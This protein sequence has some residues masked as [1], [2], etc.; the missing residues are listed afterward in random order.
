MFDSLTSELGKHP[1]K[2]CS[3]R[4]IQL[5]VEHHQGVML[6]WRFSVSDFSRETRSV[7]GC[8]C[9]SDVFRRPRLPGQWAI[10]KG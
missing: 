2:L 4:R 3:R 8:L 1:E 5:P 10:F 9:W 7:N 6:D